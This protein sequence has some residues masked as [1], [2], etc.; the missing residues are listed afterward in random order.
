MNSFLRHST[1]LLFAFG[2]SAL[3]LSGCGS[4]AP[5]DAANP[6]AVEQPARD[7]AGRLH[8]TGT[9]TLDIVATPVVETLPPARSTPI[10]TGPDPKPAVP[11]SDIPTTPP[12]AVAPATITSPD[13]AVTAAQPS[14]ASAEKSAAVIARA[15]AEQIRTKVK[16]LD[17]INNAKMPA[18]KAAVI[19]EEAKELRARIQADTSQADAPQSVVLD[20]LDEFSYYVEQAAQARVAQRLAILQ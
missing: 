9:E 4:S 5:K 16:D 6:P 13:G 12:L 14:P 20:S 1:L 19:L 3:L 11:P 18:E 15:G 2:T 17:L 8:T 7:A 10:G